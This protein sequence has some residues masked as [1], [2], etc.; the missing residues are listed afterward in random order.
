MFLP[1]TIHLCSGLFKPSGADIPVVEVFSQTIVLNGVAYVWI[2]GLNVD[3]PILLPAQSLH[4][5][6]RRGTFQQYLEDERHLT[7]EEEFDRLM[8]LCAVRPESATIVIRACEIMH[9][10][11]L[12]ADEAIVTAHQWGILL[13]QIDVADRA[14]YQVLYNEVTALKALH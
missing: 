4:E 11:G 13:S 3:A 12:P 9:A 7:L 14:S 10:E 5:F 2:D 1:S 6:R 8:E